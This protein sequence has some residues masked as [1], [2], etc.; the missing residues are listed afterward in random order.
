[1]TL[2]ARRTPARVAGADAVQV[3]VGPPSDAPAGVQFAVRSLAQFDR[4]ELAPGAVDGGDAAR[5]PARQ[6]SYWSDAK[7]QWVLDAGRP[8]RLR[9]ATPTRR[10]TCRCRRRSRRRRRQGN[11]TCS[12]EQLNATTIDGNLNVAKGD[13]CDLVDVT[14]NGDVHVDK[15]SGVRLMHVQVAHDVDIQAD[16]AADLQSSGAN[17]LCDTTVGHDLHIHGGGKNA[18]WTIGGCGPVTVGHDFHFDGNKATG[19]SISNA[20]VQHD[21][22][23]SGNGAVSGSGNTVG[24][25]KTGQCAGL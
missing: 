6:L 5:R 22:S 17:V 4:V 10:R 24:N 3:Y 21:L 25:K 23:C 16:D 9:S 15:S 20:T 8:H 1:M 11:V 12:N 14:V 2:H 19:N 18:P 13:W 7:Q